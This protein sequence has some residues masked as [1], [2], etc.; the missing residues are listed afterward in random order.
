[1]TK[2]QVN[3]FILLTSPQNFNNRSKMNIVFKW[4]INGILDHPYQILKRFMMDWNLAVS[5]RLESCMRKFCR[6]DFMFS[7]CKIK[8]WIHYFGIQA[9]KCI[10]FHSFLQSFSPTLRLPFSNYLARNDG[11]EHFAVVWIY[12][13]PDR[14]FYWRKMLQN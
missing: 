3:G 1:M 11:F 4:D 6:T 8:T 9:R 12:S 7:C 5:F 13:N 2:G 14:E 10:H